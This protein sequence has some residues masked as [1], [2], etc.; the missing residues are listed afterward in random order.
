MKLK[1]PSVVLSIVVLSCMSL[2]LQGCYLCPWGQ[3]P[4]EFAQ[5]SSFKL[6]QAL[7]KNVWV[8]LGTHRFDQAV[9]FEGGRLLIDSVSHS[10]KMKPLKANL[11]FSRY[12][13]ED[14]LMERW[15][16]AINFKANGNAKKPI[17]RRLDAFHFDPGDMLEVEAKVSK[18][19]PE[20]TQI[21][22]NMSLIF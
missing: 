1:L 13:D 9:T 6:D 8:S 4:Y 17:D 12:N 20:G 21:A 16:G 22:Y 19:V 5:Y 15:K 10:Q 3:D 14:E 2:F 18:K 11:C 7:R